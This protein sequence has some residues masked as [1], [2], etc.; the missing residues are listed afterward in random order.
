VNATKGTGRT[1]SYLNT[2]G[3]Y[4]LNGDVSFTKP[5][6]DRKFT[7]TVS[8]SGNF[9]N[10]I[11]FTD[12]KRNTGQNWVVT[13]S[14]RFRIDFTDIIDVDINGSYTI[15]KTVTQYTTY[16]RSTEVRSLNFGINGKNYFFKDWTLG[17]DFT[18]I[19]NTGYISTVNSNPVLLNLYVERRFLKRNM[20]TLRLQGFDLFNQSTGISRTVNGTTI[21]DVQNER[22]GR[23]FLLSFNLRLQKFGGKRFQRTPGQRNRDRAPGEMHS[24]DTGN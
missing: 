3:F 14:A 23:Y 24:I 2:N 16:T 8:A 12:N 17:Y 11:S 18:K 4:G 9:D 13:P 7:A 15:N 22:L 10:N 1:T 21:T 6:N 20:G 5:F 19:I